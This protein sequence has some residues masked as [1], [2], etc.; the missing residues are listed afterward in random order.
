M[1]RMLSLVIVLVVL[2]TYGCGRNPAN[3]NKSSLPSQ[4]APTSQ[5]TGSSQASQRSTQDNYTAQDLKKLS[6]ADLQAQADKVQSE[7]D[8]LLNDLDKDGEGANLAQEQ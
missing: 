3:S 1:K 5:S 7:I 8:Q 2:G 6:P 4:P